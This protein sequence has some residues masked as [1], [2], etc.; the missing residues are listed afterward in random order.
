MILKEITIQN[1][2]GYR[3]PHTFSFCDTFNLVLGPNGAGKSTLFEALTR[4]LFDRHG[5]K[6][7]EIKSARPL[8]S[9]LAPQVTVT[10]EA[11]GQRFKAEKRFLTGEFSR[12]YSERNDAWELDHEG[13]EA[14]RQLQNLLSGEASGRPVK[15]EHR[16]LAEALWY[17]QSDDP[18]PKRAW[19]LAVQQGL[20]GIL[21]IASS[22]PAEQHLSEAIAKEYAKSFTPTQKVKTGSELAGGHDRVEEAE[23]SLQQLHEKLSG[24]DQLRID[25][26]TFEE[27]LEQKQA[28]IKVSRGELAGLAQQLKEADDFEVELELQTKS[29][30]SAA[31]QADR[32]MSELAR[33]EDRIAVI[34]KLRSELRDAEEEA[35]RA[36]SSAGYNSSEAQKH[37]EQWEVSLQPE[38]KDVERSGIV[39]QALERLRRLEKDK[40]RLDSHLRRVHLVE[41]E[42]NQAKI[43]SGELLAPTS[44]EWTKYE[45]AIVALTEARARAEASAILVRF[46]LDDPT[47]NISSEPPTQLG[48]ETNE[49]P[50]TA[51]TRFDLSG[52]GGVSVRGGGESLAE[53][54]RNASGLQDEVEAIREKYEATDHDALAALRQRH[55]DLQ[56]DVTGLESRLA[57][58]QKG[59]SGAEAELSRVESGI[60][61]EEANSRLASPEWREWDGTKIRQESARLEET[62]QRLIAAI[63][64]SQDAEQVA[65]KAHIEGLGVAQEATNRRATLNAEINS[66]EQLNAEL[67]EN[68][69][70]LENLRSQVANVRHDLEDLRQKVAILEDQKEQMVSVPRR[71]NETQTDRIEGL[72]GEIVDLRLNVADRQGRIEQAAAQGLYSEIGNLEATLEY[73]RERLRVLERRAEAANLL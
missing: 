46:E 61:E 43:H 2:R 17:L 54:R 1:W 71:L 21:D 66:A 64:S 39:L 60:R 50:V 25:L 52:V 44:I 26:E 38:L 16:G 24:L 42:S 65:N 9:T 8:D 48:A 69:G 33:Y 31:E 18:L 58:L 36:E 12:L 14:D 11:G 22:S 41:E 32:V 40:D 70:T 20:S 30:A 10:L 67:L 56:Q 3:E 15:P 45:D 55:L 5:S 37:R 7:Q 28:E 34:R 73:D 68:Y 63:K 72:N 13:D 4:V 49:Y 59:N 57:E 35:S 53:L 23:H 47:I 51:P 19:N 27:S 62:K 6:A 29:V